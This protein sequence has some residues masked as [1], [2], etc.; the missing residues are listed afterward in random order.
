MKYD[1][2]HYLSYGF[3]ALLESEHSATRYRLY[4]QIQTVLE[5]MNKMDILT[6]LLNM[7]SFTR[8]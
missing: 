7:T 1:D 5:I 6:V 3:N 4:H 2:C 8:Y